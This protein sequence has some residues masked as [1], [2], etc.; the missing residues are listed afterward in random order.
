MSSCFAHSEARAL[1]PP[2]SSDGLVMDEVRFFQAHNMLGPFH[3][4]QS[5]RSVRSSA[6]PLG[7]KWCR[8]V[9]TFNFS[10]CCRQVKTVKEAIERVEVTCSL[11][12]DSA[13]FPAHMVLSCW[14][15]PWGGDR[16]GSGAQTAIRQALNLSS[17]D[18]SLEGHFCWNFF[19]PSKLW[20]LGFIGLFLTSSQ[21]IFMKEK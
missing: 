14:C 21:S 12:M 5:Y 3:A 19:F 10:Y 6:L 20:V 9:T 1:D 4:E 11:F 8:A 17:C 2:G 13:P 18:I 7:R 16:G 15:L